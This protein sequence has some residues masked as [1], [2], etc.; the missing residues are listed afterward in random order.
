MTAERRLVFGT[1]DI[2]AIRI[3]CG[4]TE[5][6]AEMLVDIEANVEMPR[7][8]PHCNTRWSGRH[9]DQPADLDMLKYVINDLPRN[10]E[11]YTIRFEIDAAD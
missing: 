11:G 1:D 4:K 5:C 10:E 3:T 7:F 8:C 2:R 6:G 9:N